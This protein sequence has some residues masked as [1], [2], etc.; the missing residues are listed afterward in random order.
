MSD[1]VEAAEVAPVPQTTLVARDE[2]GYVGLMHMGDKVRTF[3][4]GE[5]AH[6]R[7]LFASA[8]ISE[9]GMDQA[10]AD[11]MAEAAVQKHADDAMEAEAKSAA[12]PAA[13][14]AEPAEWMKPSHG[15]VVAE[16]EA[17]PAPSLAAWPEPAAVPIADEGGRS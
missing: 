5:I 15:A 17:A 8:G 13:E 6:A 10:G 14:P 9:F 4:A 7:K 11:A 2:G 12:E 16:P 1:E 3:I